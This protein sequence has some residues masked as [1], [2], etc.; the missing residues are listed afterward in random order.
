MLLRH[1][2]LQIHTVIILIAAQ[3]AHPSLPVSMPAHQ[4]S[5]QI[6]YRQ[7]RRRAQRTAV[8][9]RRTCA[10]VKREHVALQR[11]APGEDGAAGVAQD[12]LRR[13]KVNRGDVLGEFRAVRE[14]GGAVRARQTAREG[15]VMAAASDR[16]R[17]RSYGQTAQNLRMKP[18]S[19]YLYNKFNP[20]R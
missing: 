9:H 11:A 13:V 4:V 3:R 1:V 6:I 5:L 14:G 17:S 10:S 18:V 15:A 2:P 7:E 8:R 16:R 12:R 19:L 20:N